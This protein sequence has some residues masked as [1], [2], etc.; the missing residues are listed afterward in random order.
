MLDFAART[1][2][3]TESR[4]NLAQLAAWGGS[5]AQ[6]SLSAGRGRIPCQRAFVGLCRDLGFGVRVWM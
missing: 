3:F 4:K 6:A 1:L 5:F 2:L